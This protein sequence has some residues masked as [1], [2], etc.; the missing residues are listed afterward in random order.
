MIYLLFFATITINVELMNGTTEIIECETA[1]EI[2]YQP[3]VKFISVD[4]CQKVSDVIFSNSF[5]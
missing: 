2:N 4:R 5:E 1:E 3:D